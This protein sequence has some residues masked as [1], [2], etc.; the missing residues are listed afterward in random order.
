MPGSD[1]VRLVKMQKQLGV[2]AAVLLPIVAC[3]PLQSTFSHSSAPKSSLYSIK[4]VLSYG[5]SV[6]LPSDARVVLQV[7]EGLGTNWPVVVEY[8]W[9]VRGAQ[10]P[11]EYEMM[12]PRSS[13]TQD[14][15]CFV[16][17]GILVDGLLVF[18]SPIAQIKLGPN[19]IDV[20]LLSLIV[21]A[22]G[23]FSTLLT[24]GP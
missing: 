18:V 17:A 12:V 14:K 19:R 2:A 11:L 24:R 6:I 15:N 7:R 21:A 8:Q 10:F 20:G 13:L 5:E 1:L 16:R 9:D 4:G 22:P 23:A 3:A